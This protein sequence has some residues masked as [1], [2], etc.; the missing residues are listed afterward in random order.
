MRAVAWSLAAAA[1]LDRRRDRPRLR[2][3]PRTT[4]PALAGDVAFL[5]VTASFAVAGLAILR[6]EPR[7]RIGW[8]FTAIGVA[9]AER[10]RRSACTGISRWPPTCPPARSSRRSPRP[11][12]APPVVAMGTSLLFRFPDGELPSRRWRFVEPVAGAVTR[13]GD[14]RYLDRDPRPR[15]GRPSGRREPAV[16]R[17]RQAARRRA[18]GRGR[19]APGRDRRLRGRADHAVPSLARRRASPDEVARR[20]GGRRSRSRTSSR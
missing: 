4:G 16:R 18:D 17:V 2:L 13:D 8:I 14:R 1:W 3:V 12:W 7:N 10:D 20:R 9:W 6:R 15:R 11:L 5:V 19:R